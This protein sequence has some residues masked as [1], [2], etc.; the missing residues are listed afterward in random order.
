M[1]ALRDAV[2][3]DGRMPPSRALLGA[4]VLLTGLGLLGWSLLTDPG[5][6]LKRKAYILQP[7]WIIVGCALLAPLLVRPLARLLTWFPA[8]LP[9]ATGLLARQ[10]ASTS[11]RRTASVAAPV[12]I[13]VALAGSLLG[14][15]AT[16]DEARATEATAVSGADFVAAWGRSAGP[17]F[18]PAR[19]ER[20][21]SRG[22][23]LPLHRGHRPGGGHRAHLVG[24]T[25]GRSGGPGRDRAAAPRRLL[26][27]RTWTTAPS[28]STRSG[29]HGPSENTCASGWA[30]A[31]RCRSASRL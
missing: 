22:L 23:C 14:T 5:D 19:T 16:I 13:T 1:E 10:N 30:T 9:G 21:R 18:R 27:P 17:P 3:D 24:G 6:V 12:L 26:L 8:R 11:V 4:A 28:S 31:A 29:R 15:V 7:M 25:R 20:P 2:V